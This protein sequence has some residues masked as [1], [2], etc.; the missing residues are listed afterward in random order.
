MRATVIPY[1]IPFE[2]FIFFLKLF[3]NNDIFKVIYLQK[4]LVGKSTWL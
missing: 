3:Y 1:F 4:N 2:L